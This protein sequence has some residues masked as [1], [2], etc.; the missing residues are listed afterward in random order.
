MS[1]IKGLGILLNDIYPNGDRAPDDFSHWAVEIP[2]S[3]AFYHP[4]AGE[5]RSAYAVKSF[6]GKT[7]DTL[8]TTNSLQEPTAIVPVA[9][10]NHPRSPDKA[11]VDDLGM[12]M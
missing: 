2:M 5:L 11:Q 12:S 6:L 8:E 3:E 1:E 9:R 10:S 7:A 4:S